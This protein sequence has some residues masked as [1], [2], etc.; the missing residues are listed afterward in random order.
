MGSAFY[1]YAISSSGS[2]S[3][4]YR[5]MDLYKVASIFWAKVPPGS[6]HVHGYIIVGCVSLGTPSGKEITTVTS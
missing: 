4:Y 3:R 2:F 1:T 6:Y 5:R